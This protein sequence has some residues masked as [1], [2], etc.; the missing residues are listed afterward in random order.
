[1]TEG[2]ED[3]CDVK[4]EALLNALADTVAEVEAATLY[5]TL[6]VMKAETLVEEVD[7]TIAKD[8]GRDTW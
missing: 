7:D 8:G 6:S 1:M 2:C 3:V 5:E 4:A